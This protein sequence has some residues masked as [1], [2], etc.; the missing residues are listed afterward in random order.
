MSL[1]AR[2]QQLGHA[3]GWGS[4]VGLLVPPVLGLRPKAWILHSPLRAAIF[5]AHT[6]PQDGS[7]TTGA[8]RPGAGTACPPLL[9]WPL[10]S[11]LSTLILFIKHFHGGKFL[12]PLGAS[13][14]KTE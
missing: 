13:V 9:L 3:G 1:A 4:V 5:K 6:L 8:L 12:G 10:A 14:E 7:Y 2:G 11:I